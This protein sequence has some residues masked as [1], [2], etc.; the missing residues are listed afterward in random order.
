MIGYLIGYSISPFSNH[1]VIGIL[2]LMVALLAHAAGNVIND[3]H[4][5]L[6]GTDLANV[7]RIYPFTGGSR[8]IQDGIFTEQKISRFATTLFFI[9]ILLGIAVIYFSSINLVL[10]GVLGLFL[11]WAY[12]APPCKLMSR[13]LIG[14]LSITLAWALVVI[15]AAMLNDINH[16]TGNGL[17]MSIVIGLSYGFA[18]ANILF[19]NQIPDINAD[20]S[21]QKRTLAATIQ[22]SNIWVYYLCFNLLAYLTIL[23][24]YALGLLG[25]TYLLS[26]LASPI[27][28]Y[29]TYILKV[30]PNQRPALRQAITLTIISAHIYGALLLLSNVFINYF[31]EPSKVILN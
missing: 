23:I 8:M 20:L 18:V 27:H 6:N 4:D 14:E 1:W 19:V 21:V 25:V 9:A 28:L 5:S 31:D 29:I 30:S 26:L 13:G 12:S 3:F 17:L 2:G 10:I 15:G 11:A 22:M 16:I 24:S 7:E